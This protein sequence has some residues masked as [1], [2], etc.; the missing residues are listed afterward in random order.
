M[1]S[2]DIGVFLTCT[3]T[4]KVQFHNRAGTKFGIFTD[5]LRKE[6]DDEQQVLFSRGELQFSLLQPNF[7]DCPANCTLSEIKTAMKRRAKGKSITEVIKE[8]D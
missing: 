3:E 2:L 7:I 5:Q 6:G 4:G 1:N 8:H